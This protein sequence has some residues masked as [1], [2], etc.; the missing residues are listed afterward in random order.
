VGN[1]GSGRPKE[2]ALRCQAGGRAGGGD[3]GGG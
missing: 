1:R 3:G 2:E